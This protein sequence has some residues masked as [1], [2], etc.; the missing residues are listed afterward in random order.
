MP[1]TRA[2]QHRCEWSDSAA[3]ANRTSVVASGSKVYIVCSSVV[4]PDVLDL[5]RSHP[6]RLGRLRHHRLEFGVDDVQFVNGDPSSGSYPDRHRCRQGTH[7]PVCSATLSS[8]FV[9]GLLRE[10]GPRAVDVPITERVMTL[11]F[12]G[13]SYTAPAVLPSFRS[14]EKSSSA[15]SEDARVVSPTQTAVGRHH[16][17]A[18]PLGAWDAPRVMDGPAQLRCPGGEHLGDLIGDRAGPPP[19]G[20]APS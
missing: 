17:N 20:T 9:L 5:H 18:G 19:A 1:R 8:I 3:A 16:Q 4:F 11:C 6:A 15:T 14:R 12:T 13:R 2:R 7:R 10:A